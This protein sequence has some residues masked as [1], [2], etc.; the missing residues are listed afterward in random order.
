MKFKERTRKRTGALCSWR[1][2]QIGDIE[3]PKGGMINI[4][5]DTFEKGNGVV[6]GHTC[7]NLL[8]VS[9]DTPILAVK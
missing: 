5:L 2:H 1:S 7:Q 4:Q 9:Q 6:R 3:S 8:K